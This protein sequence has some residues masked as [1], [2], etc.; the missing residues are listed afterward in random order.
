[1]APAPVPAAP[2]L[3]TLRQQYRTDKAAL[4]DQLGVQGS[5][6][7][8]VRKALQQLSRLTDQTLREL[9]SLAG[10]GPGFSLIAVGGFG[11]GELFPHSDVD[12][13]VLLPD[14]SR[15]T[16]T[17]RSRPAWKA[18]SAPAGTWAWRSAP[19]C[20]PSPTAWTRRRKT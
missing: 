9:W 8:G 19:A 15:P 6:T 2:D 4:L 20:A 12:V 18:S 11:R 1:M 13:L 7:R 5:S 10:F 3:G 16:T 17:P 14:G